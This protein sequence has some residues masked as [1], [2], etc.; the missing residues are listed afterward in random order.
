MYRSSIEFNKYNKR[1][2]KT[3]FNKSVIQY[4][5]YCF[6]SS[7]FQLSI[8]YLIIIQNITNLAC[9][10]V[11]MVFV[12]PSLSRYTSIYFIKNENFIVAYLFHLL[13][14]LLVFYS[15][16]FIH[17]LSTIHPLFP[18]SSSFQ[19]FSRNNHGYTD[20]VL[21]IVK[22]FNPFQVLQI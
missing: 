9:N 21:K 5:Q 16:L 20:K 1:I 13:L 17:L 3:Y 18:S 12:Y 15:F 19:R 10:T 22:I 6:L 8:F 14:S 2:S 7:L 4:K 11:V